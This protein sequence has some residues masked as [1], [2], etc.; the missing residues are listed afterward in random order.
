M[1]VIFIKSQSLQVCMSQPGI[2]TLNKERDK[3][4]TRLIFDLETTGLIDNLMERILCIC[5]YNVEANESKT[6]VGDDEGK[7][8]QDFFDYVSSLDTPN[9][10]G[11][12]VDSFDLPFMVR[13][14][15]VHKKKIPWFTNTDLRKVANGFRFS[16]NRNEKGKLRDWAAILGMKVDTLPGS[17]MFKL[18]HE[19]KFNE[20]EKHC[21]EDIEITKK[22]YEHVEACGLVSSR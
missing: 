16:Y 18:Y 2:S 20:I 11:Y 21:Q 8:L 17:E 7:I 9:L 6:F 12:N 4:M 10:I 19:K 14:A 22:L 1:I 5:V 3:E 15:V 13:R